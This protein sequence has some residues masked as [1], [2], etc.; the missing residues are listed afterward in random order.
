[1]MLG[2]RP[3]FVGA[4]L[5]AAIEQLDTDVGETILGVFHFA[6]AVGSSEPPWLPT[7]V[8]LLTDESLDIVLR[9]TVAIDLS[10]IANDFPLFIRRLTEL[11][12][13]SMAFICTEY[14]AIIAKRQTDNGFVTSVERE[15]DR[16]ALN[17]ILQTIRAT[18]VDANAGN[19]GDLVTY[20]GD[21]IA[22]TKTSAAATFKSE[23]LS[24]AGDVGERFDNT[25]PILLRTIFP[26]LVDPSSPLVR[27]A[28]ATACAEI[29]KRCRDA[30][31]GDVQ[32]ILAGLLADEYLEPVSGAIR[33]FG[34]AE[35]KDEQL[36]SR[37]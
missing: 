9:R 20:I 28:A 36:A 15:G 5:F 25:R 14:D 4:H 7:L 21:I 16:I 24:L 12:L 32:V 23:M 34:A 17:F 30:L 8:S 19:Q 18:I 13:G 37:L 29:A 11:L 6:E 10:R 22:N 26:S 1:M 33:A 3:A 35:V 27:A 2:E 31:S